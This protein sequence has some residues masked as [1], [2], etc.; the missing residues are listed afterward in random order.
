MDTSDPKNQ[1]EGDREAAR[2]FNEDEQKFVQSG[3]TPEAARRAAPR[4]EN[5]ARQMQQAE[6]A[7]RSHAKDEDPTVPG[8]NATHK[9]QGNAKP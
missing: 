8:A 1:G 2:R 4:D 7:G 3:R 5:E 9:P 6:E